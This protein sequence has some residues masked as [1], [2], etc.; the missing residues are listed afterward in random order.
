MKKII[1]LLVFA[2]VA[3][4]GCGGATAANEQAVVVTTGANETVIENY[5][6]EYNEQGKGY[7]VSWEPITDDYQATL[8]TRL[9]G[10]S[11]TCVMVVDYTLLPQLVD[12]GKLLP[13]DDYLTDEKSSTFVSSVYDS[14][15]YEGNQY[16]LP[17][18]YNTL[19]VFYNKDMFDAAGVD[20]PD[21]TWTWQ[22]YVDA[23]AIIQ[24]TLEENQVAFSAGNEYH[25]WRE[26]VLANGGDLVDADGNFDFTNE[27]AVTAFEQWM[28]LYED[29]YYL[30]PAELGGTWG[31]DVFF[32]ENAAITIE[33]SWAISAIEGGNPDLNW[34]ATSIPLAEE[35]GTQ[36]T[37]IYS[38]AL[39]IS[40]DCANAGGAYEWMDWFT[41]E[42]MAASRA[43]YQKAEGTS[44]GGIPSTTAQKD[45]YLIDYP[46]Y[47]IF[48]DAGEYGTQSGLGTIYDQ[49]IQDNINAVME[50][51][52]Y[53]SSLDAT[54]QLQK[55]QDKATEEA[56]L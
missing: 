1:G 54:E 7:T 5:I 39:A 33:G 17:L 35:N 44:S 45:Q 11:D 2:V 4:T 9:A 25:R 31:G 42:E 37:M 19:G 10:G 28:Q 56:G 23:M 38:N 24:P 3:L 27:A 8:S 14:F 20:Y 30:T 22:D 55:A 50:E 6:N 32:Q 52:L 49:I 16:G 29:G 43:E 34:G 40:S 46:E 21:E 51:S 18:D 15:N 12:A 48:A 53:D 41:T 13:L 26:L 36:S 47:Q